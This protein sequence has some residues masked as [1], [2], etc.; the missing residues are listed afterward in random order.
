MYFQNRGV[1]MVCNA[2]IHQVFLNI[3]VFFEKPPI[4]AV[5]GNK[6]TA[7]LQMEL[8]CFLVRETGL[9]PVRVAPHAPQTCASADS[10]TLASTICIISNGNT[11]VNTFFEKNI[12]FQNNFEMYSGLSIIIDGCSAK[13]CSNE[14][15]PHEQPTA[16]IPAFFAVC[17]STSLSPK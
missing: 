9:E 14:R 3:L 2:Y 8:S 12:N 16:S 6:K 1:H 5:F 11:N 13:S 10:A 4:F 17:I 7:Q 15:K